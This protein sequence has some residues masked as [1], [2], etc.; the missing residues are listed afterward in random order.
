MDGWINGGMVSVGCMDD[1]M[2]S[3]DG[4]N[5]C[6]DSWIELQHG[7]KDLMDRQIGWMNTVVW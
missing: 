7:W 5:A 2:V 6:M 1:W 4:W 3:M